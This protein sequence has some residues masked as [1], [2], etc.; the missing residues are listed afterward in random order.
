MTCSIWFS[1]FSGSSGVAANALRI[2]PGNSDR[3]AAPAA[4]APRPSKNRRRVTPSDCSCCMRAPSRRGRLQHSMSRNG[5]RYATGNNQLREL[6]RRWAAPK[7]LISGARRSFGEDV[8]LRRGPGGLQ[9]IMYPQH[10]TLGIAPFQFVQVR[11]PQPRK[12]RLTM[13]RT[14]VIQQPLGFAPRQA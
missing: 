8:I 9:V 4:V 7:A 2:E 10:K 1:D 14:T 6:M 13:G 5:Y 3:L 12:G 11:G